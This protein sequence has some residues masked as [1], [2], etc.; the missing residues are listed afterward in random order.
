V[1]MIS[2]DGFRWDYPAMVT[3]PTLDSLARVGVKATSL[4]PA[5]PSITFPNHYS[6]ATGLYPDHHGIVSNSFYDSATKKQ[7][8][9]GNRKAVEDGT[10]YGGE[11]IWVTA[12]KQGMRSASFFW[13]GSEAPIQGIQPTYWK[14]Y[15][16]KIPMGARGDTVIAWLSLPAERRPHLIL[17]YHHEPDGVGHKYGP[18]SDEVKA[19]IESLDRE[20]GVLFT[21]INQLSIASEINVIVTSDHGMQSTSP[22]RSVLLTDY[23]HQDWFVRVEGYSPVLLFEVK[24]EY[25][26]EAYGELK[27]IP[28]CS[29]WPSK[30]VPLRLHYGTNPRTL[31]FVLLADSGWTIRKNALQKVGKGAHGYDPENRN[32]HAIFYASGPAFKKGYCSKGFNNIDLYPLLTRLLGLVPAPV[33]G[34]FDHVSDLILN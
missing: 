7:F 9:V 12:E 28:H 29:V 31:D 26:V 13:V 10:F 22:E 8:A 2:L 33:D 16:E 14:R 15:D 19:T 17:L 21:K 27:R 18:E 1:L 3:L 4:K 25:D 5:F 23:I 11:P 32:M 24:P 34:T 6:M 20:L 30:E